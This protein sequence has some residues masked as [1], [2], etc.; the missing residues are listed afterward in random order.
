MQIEIT[1]SINLPDPARLELYR[2]SPE[3]APR[4]LFFTGGSA[5]RK[6]SEELIYYTH[7]SIHIITPMDS[8]GSSA[9]LRDAFQMPAIGDIRNRLM[10]LADRSLTGNPE[11]LKLFSC[12]FPKDA[13]VEN[14]REELAR[15]TEG[16]HPLI[17]R[18]PDPMRKIIRQYLYSF[19]QHMPADFD[20]CGASIGNLVLAS[21]YL[22]NRRHLDPVIYVFSKLANVRGIV[23]PV[24]SRNLHLVAE[25]ENGVVLAGQ[26][27]LTGKEVPPID[28][29]VQRVY[30][31]ESRRNPQPAVVSIREKMGSWIAEADL[32]CYPMGSFYSSLVANLLPEGV[33]TAIQGNPCPKVFIPNTGVDPELFGLDLAGQVDRL[34]NY[35]CKDDPAAIKTRDVL[36][37]ILV[38]ERSGHY[39]GQ[40]NPLRLEKHGIKVIN[41]RLVSMR[42][43][44]Y[45]DE[46]LLVPILLSLA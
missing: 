13:P 39:N 37:F 19:L 41:C 1:R 35:L 10:A 43:T 2:R 4:I 21:G 3:I 14:L 24:T 11:I 6:V 20:L 9:K 16:H 28:S 34:L 44:P 32:I 26:H 33:G 22:D 25:L 8:G 29:M 12:R 42:S 5:L 31:S 36:N 38:D 27:L 40:L 30:L 45:I 23:R 15:M 7:N 17:K 18:I 46:K